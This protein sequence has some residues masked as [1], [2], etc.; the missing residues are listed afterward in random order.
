LASRVLSVAW[1]KLKSRRENRGRER[2][3]GETRRIPFEP[4]S[5]LKCNLL[6][7]TG[8]YGAKQIFRLQSLL[9]HEDQH[10]GGMSLL[11]LLVQ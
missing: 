6:P 5:H 9:A 7:L 4:A 2:R 1:G 10:M 3:R 8:N 11:A